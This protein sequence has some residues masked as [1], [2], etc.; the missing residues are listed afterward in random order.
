MTLRNR[1]LIATATM[2]L[3]PTA[4]ANAQVIDAPV[5]VQAAQA[6]F[7]W[8][9]FYFGGHV[10]TGSAVIEDVLHLPATDQYLNGLLGGFQAGYDIQMGRYLVIGAVGDLS[11]A[12][13]ANT[14]D[15]DH[16]YDP[17]YTSN[18]ASMIATLRARAGIVFAERALVYGTVG[19]IWAKT[20]HMLGC[21]P[22]HAPGGTLGCSTIFE[23]TDAQTNVGLVF[24]G[25]VE[26]AVAEHLSLA[27][28]ALHGT[29]NYPVTLTDPNYSLIQREFETAISLLRLNVNWRF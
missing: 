29:L 25:G 19:A 21:S 13:I 27:I 26:V 18:T 7:S 3:V 10:G 23:V 15:G 17:Y 4:A 20:E 22:S 14:W 6:D 16:Q 2:T 11:F 5:A 1:M 28:E 9:G 24:G 12:N 8:T